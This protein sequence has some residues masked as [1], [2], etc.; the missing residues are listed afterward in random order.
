MTTN[1]QPKVLQRMLLRTLLLVL[2]LGALVLGFQWFTGL[3]GDFDLAPANTQGM[4]AA[5]EYD[6]E[7]GQRLVAFRADGT[8]VTN[9]GWTAGV[10]DRDP[11]WSLDGNRVFF[12]SDRGVSGQQGVKSFNIFRWNPDRNDAPVQRSIGT[13]SPGNPSFQEH[14]TDD[15][16]PTAL[17]TSGGFVVEFND[18]E[19]TARQVLPPVGRGISTTT[20]DEAGTENQIA[21]LYGQFGQSFRVAKWFAGRQFIAAIMRREEGEVLIIQELAPREI[22]MP[23]GTTT[24]GLDRPRPVVAGDR[25]DMAVNPK[26]GELVYVVQGFRWLDERSIPEEFRRNN[27]VTVPFHHAIG[28]VGV[29]GVDLPPV[30]VSPDPSQSFAAPTISPDGST[31]IIVAGEMGADN[32]EP[33]ALVSMPASSGGAASGTAL[34]QGEIFEPTWSPDGE[35]LVMV[36]RSGG[37]RALFTIAKDGSDEKALST[38][39]SYESP[40][41]SPQ[42]SASP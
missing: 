32:F 33:R 12:V 16:G 38:D 19:K 18:K 11:T 22:K 40:R 4:I 29:D 26:S 21:A 20:D 23:D 2:V 7:D 25:I 34:A 35:R 30:A 27:R 9:A 10:I 41:F 3:R 42:V 15:R 39:G 36:K 37:K 8:K 14:I 13:R 5:I 17:L 28:L 24:R 31:L 1:D 6:E